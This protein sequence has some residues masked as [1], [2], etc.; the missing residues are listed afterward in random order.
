MSELL[1]VALEGLALALGLMAAVW[2]AGMV[3]RDASLVDRFWGAGFVLLAWYYAW[4]L[5]APPGGGW[6]RRLVLLLVTAW[7]LRL[8]LHI[9]W[10]NWGHGED[11]RYRAMRESGGPGW[12][13]RSLVTVNGLQGMILWVVSAPLLAAMAAPVPARPPLVA[14]G[15]LAWGVG[16]A[17]EAGGDW[18]LARFKA[19][20]AN[21]GKVLDR[22]FWRY[23][24][25]PNY[26]GDALCWW[27]F[28]GLATAVG[29]GWTVFS[30]LLMTFLLMKVSGV[31]L[32]EKALLETKPAYRDYVRRTNAFLP[33][34]P[35]GA[36]PTGRP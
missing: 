12:P 34:R 26:F 13:L 24:R 6:F 32:L 20:A 18:Q 3:T 2:A 25:H 27:G 30:P 1:G 29:G 35:R 36:P 17:F 5:P 4:A 7:G 8:S 16:F 33:G 14:L 19:D 22:G 11:P 9:T 23:T 10:R 15:V 28:F 31:S 21:R